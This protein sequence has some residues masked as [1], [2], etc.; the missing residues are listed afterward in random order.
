MFPFIS[1]S[2]YS[3]QVE[4]VIS[5]KLIGVVFYDNAPLYNLSYVYQTPRSDYLP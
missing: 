1:L 5:N 2:L 3:L 4:G